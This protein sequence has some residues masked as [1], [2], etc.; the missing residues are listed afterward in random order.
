M[1]DRFQHFLTGITVCYKYIQRIKNAE[2]AEFGLKGTHVACMFYLH[3]HPQ[4]LTAAQLCNLCCEDKAA[5]SRIVSD[6]CARGYIL[7]S[8]GKNY[9]APL[10][11]SAAGNAIAQQMDPLIESWV[12]IGSEGL[13]DADRDAFYHSLDLISE[14]LKSKIEP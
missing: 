1:I 12:T 4:G 10:R 14:N 5:I 3:H 7:Q 2:M 6:L 8:E 9:R 11:L 13:T